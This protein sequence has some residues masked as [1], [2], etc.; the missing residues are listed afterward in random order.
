MKIKNK[1]I[2]IILLFLLLIPLTGCTKIL[3]DENKK[4]VQNTKTGQNLVENILCQP[5]DSTTIEIYNQHNIE[6]NNLPK[7]SNFKITSG[8]YE[9]IW[10]TIFV[11]PLAWV[12]I[13]I[14]KL[15]KNYGLSVIIVTILI[16][17]IM[18]PMT[19]KTAMQS[20]NMKKAQPELEKLEKKYKNRQDNE[21]M[22]QKSQEMMLIYKKNNIS[23]LSGC[24]YSIIQIPLFFAFYEAMNRI[25]ALFEETLIGFQLG[26]SPLTAMSSGKFYYLIFVVLVIVATYFSFKLNSTAG[27]SS[28][29]EKQMKMMTNISIVLISIASFTISTGIALYWIFNSGFTILQNLLVKRRK[30]NDN[31]I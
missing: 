2:V 10:T 20:E 17:L 5:E 13:Q 18:Y 26:T 16:R 7:C 8:G 23:P 15:V 19:K 30:K 11:K 22:M 21:S 9:G 14:G 25:P 4:T 31:I 1:K 27:I 12:I 6:I 29:Q 3:K 28:D 24:L